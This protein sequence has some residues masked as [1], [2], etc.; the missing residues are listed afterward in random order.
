MP[1]TASAPRKTPS[2]GLTYLIVAAI[3]GLLLLIG[4]LPD[5]GS[6]SVSLYKAP[7]TQQTLPIR[8]DVPTTEPT[9]A[10]LPRPTSAPADTGAPSP[11]ATIVPAFMPSPE[12]AP[13]PSPTQAVLTYVLNTN[14]RRFHLPECSSARSIKEKN[15]STFTG[16]REDIL[17]LGYKPCGN[18]HP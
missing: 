18:C 2:N 11:T 10:P 12:D 6:D 7:E 8:T 3:L 17:E 1:K 9:A 4:L 16:T 14:T 5:R 15:R 13:S